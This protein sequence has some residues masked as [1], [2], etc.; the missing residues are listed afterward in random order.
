[1][2]TRRRRQWMGAAALAWLM[3]AH[4]GTSPAA[5]T[6]GEAAFEHAVK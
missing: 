6:H 3:V 5:D 1:M 4:A 2:R